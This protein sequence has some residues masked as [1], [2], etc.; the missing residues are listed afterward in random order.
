M[1]KKK[2]LRPPCWLFGKSKTS[3][4]VSSSQ[5]ELSELYNHAHKHEA[6]FCFMYISRVVCIS[7]MRQWTIANLHRPNKGRNDLYNEWIFLSTNDNNC[8]ITQNGD[9]THHYNTAHWRVLPICHSSKPTRKNSNQRLQTLA[10]TCFVWCILC[11][12][13]V[14]VCYIIN[15]RHNYNCHFINAS[16]DDRFSHFREDFWRFKK[17]KQY[18]CRITYPMTIFLYTILS[19]DDPQKFSYW[20]AV[21][22]YMCNYDVI[23]KAPMMS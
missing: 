20:S 10:R 15:K 13:Y 8:R 2:I 16:S 3:L 14:L 11:G 7:R 4:E 23:P 5:F 12:V 22:F 19:L 18:G 17:T 1:V 6:C 21:A 9:D